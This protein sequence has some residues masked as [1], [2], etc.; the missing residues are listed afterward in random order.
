MSGTN[1]VW[2]SFS[3]VSESRGL[4]RRLEPITPVKQEKRRKKKRTRTPAQIGEPTGDTAT[5]I[6]L[7]AS[8]CVYMYAYIHQVLATKSYA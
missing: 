5:G 6:L 2:F 8:L 7:I 3:A 4:P 1:T